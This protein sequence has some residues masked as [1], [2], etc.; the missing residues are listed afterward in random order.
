MRRR[1]LSGRPPVWG[2]L[3]P[4][5]SAQADQLKK[6]LGDNSPVVRIAA[7]RA[8]CLMGQ[9]QDAL[10]T[11]TEQLASD[12]QWVRLHAAI[13]LDTLGDK[14]RPAIPALQT[15]LGDKQNKYVVRVANHALNGLEGT[16][17]RVP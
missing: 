15:A 11:L 8:L 7:A 5:A 4:K 3:G 10:D 17:N 12:H 6:M 14:A 16:Q 2:N 1:T 13:A 9:E